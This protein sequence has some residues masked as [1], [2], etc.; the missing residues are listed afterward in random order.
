MHKTL[1][2]KDFQ[3]MRKTLLALALAASS[4]LTVAAP[5]SAST[6]TCVSRPE[7]DLLEKGMT[8]GTVHSIFDFNGTLAFDNPESGY[9]GRTYKRCR[10]YEE[11]LT[12]IYYD[13]GNS[14][15]VDNWTQ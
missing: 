11:P 6:P 15:R 7:E 4:V 2:K 14:W 9:R 5:A 12:V 8:M 10:D 1:N 3:H 13:A